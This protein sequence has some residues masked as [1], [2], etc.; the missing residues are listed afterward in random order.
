MGAQLSYIG[1]GKHCGGDWDEKN[2]LKS[3][4]WFSILWDPLESI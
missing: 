2:K 1:L 4:A 3:M